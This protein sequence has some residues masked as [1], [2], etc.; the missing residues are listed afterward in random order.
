MTLPIWLHALARR[1]V[2]RVRGHQD[3]GYDTCE[4]CRE[5]IR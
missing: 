3:V 2:C 4:R 1:A 5:F